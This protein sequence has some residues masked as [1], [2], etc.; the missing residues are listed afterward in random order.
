MADTDWKTEG[1]RLVVANL[2]EE[3]VRQLLTPEARGEYLFT[4]IAR[5]KDH[6]EGDILITEETN[7]GELLG[8]VQRR[9]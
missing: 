5:W 2:L 7:A 8:L 3:R 4:F 9:F 1:F 6:P